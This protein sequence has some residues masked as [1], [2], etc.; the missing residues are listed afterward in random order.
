[1]SFRFNPLVKEIPSIGLLRGIAS[2]MVCYFHL[3]Y[4]NPNFLPPESIVRQ[5]GEWGWTGV[6]V[7]FIISGFVIPYSMFVSRYTPSKVWIF[8]KKRIVRIEP[9]YLL[10]IVLLLLLNYLSSLVPS[11][12]GAPFELDWKNIA[13]HVAY[14]NIFTGDKWLQDVYW[15]LAVEFQYY[16]LIALVY[17]LITSKRLWIRLAF[18]ISFLALMFLGNSYKGFIMPHTA[19]FMIGILMF[20]YY[21]NIIQSKEFWL[22]LSLGFAM[23]WYMYGWQLVAISALSLSVMVFVK[24]VHPVFRFLGTISFSL[25][26]VHLPIGGR[27]NNLAASFVKEMHMREVVV[28]ISFAVSIF[29]AWLYYITIEKRCKNLSAAL[30]YKQEA[31]PIAQQN[32][33]TLK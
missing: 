25:Y 30:Q 6:Q 27:I 21:C 31:R 11:Y 15:T 12:K 9:P 23:V 24:N 4:G 20:Q 29:A 3:A 33:E 5:S 14:L 18:C 10:S 19:Y 26:L 13:S 8:I 2:A 32:I 1:M 28:F 16:L 22:L 17:G 7:F